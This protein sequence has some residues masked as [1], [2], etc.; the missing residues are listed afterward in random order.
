MQSV[1]RLDRQPDPGLPTLPDGVVLRPLASVGDDRGEVLEVFRDD[2][3]LAARPPQ[4]TV[5]ANCAGALRGV[6]VHRAHDDYLVVLRG[7]VFLGM[8]DLRSESRTAWRS[9][10]LEL[11]GA[12]PTAVVIPHGVA[13]G[14]LSLSAATFLLGTS[15]TYDP[16]DDL[17][18]HWRDPELEV[19]WPAVAPILS[20]RDAALPSLRELL[21]VLAA[22]RER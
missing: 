19:D 1:R 21:A 17:G 6:H 20:P 3:T 2:W 4:W 22:E 14:L 12:Q 9:A 11:R 10:G 7:V 16:S 13:H 8:R 18:C 5:F 15:H